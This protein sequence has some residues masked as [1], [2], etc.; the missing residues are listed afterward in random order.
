MGKSKKRKLLGK[1]KDD[2]EF[3]LPKKHL[4]TTHL[5]SLEKRLIIILEGAQLETVKVCSET[6]LLYV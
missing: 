1:S 4:K 6:N 5:K 3:D 2:T